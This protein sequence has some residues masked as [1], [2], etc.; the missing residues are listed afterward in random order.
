MGL[1]DKVKAQ[2]GQL[3]DRAQVAGKVGQAKIEA[4]QAKR[5]ADSQLEEI[6][7]MTYL[8]EAGR[9][10][11]AFASRIAELVESIRRYE[12]EFGLISA[13]AD[14]GSDSATTPP[15]GGQADASEGTG[16]ASA[17]EGGTGGS[18][19]GA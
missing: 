18:G 7:R 2:A 9:G 19:D 5:K 8:G 12:A 13:D 11:A 10:D 6:G 3:A 14:G 4:I 16:G 15:G 1:M 17:G